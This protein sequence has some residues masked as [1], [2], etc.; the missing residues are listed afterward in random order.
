MNAELILFGRIISM[1]Q[2]GRR[3][4]LVVAIYAILA[5]ALIGSYFSSGW[6]TVSPYIILGTI[7]ACRIFLGGYYPGGLVKK[8]N[9][10][11]ARQFE[12]PPV[13]AL[14]LRVYRPV[15]GVGA[16][17]YHNDERELGLRDRAHYH[18]YRILAVSLVVPWF[19]SSFSG[20]VWSATNSIHLCAAL[21]LAII[22]LSLTLPQ[23]ILLWTEPD[24]E[25]EQ[26][27]V[28]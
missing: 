28:N 11:A 15:P 2:R 8:F 13:L 20:E 27:P 19:V 5:G 17:V 6:R 16:D 1:A 25:P 24:M 23:A 12:A 18:A 21:L 22:T 10:N 7:L 14:K 26:Q 9:N 3:R 4:V